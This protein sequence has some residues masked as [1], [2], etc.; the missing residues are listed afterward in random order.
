MCYVKN[1]LIIE[2]K[3]HNNIFHV[4]EKKYLLTLYTRGMTVR[5]P[6]AKLLVLSDDGCTLVLEWTF[7]FTNMITRIR[8]SRIA[9]SF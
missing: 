8:A 1:Q 4:C 5:L 6:F 2:P 9:D 3:T 7:H